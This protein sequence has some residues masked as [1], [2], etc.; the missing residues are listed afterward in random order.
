M[1]QFLE[2][3]SQTLSVCSR[4]SESVWRVLTLRGIHA[5]AGVGM[6]SHRV[7]SMVD[8]VLEILK[9][10]TTPPQSAELKNALVDLGKKSVTLWTAAQKDAAKVVV[11]ARPDPSDINKWYAEDVQSVGK[12][13]IQPDG[14]IDLTRIEPFCTFPA[15]IQMTAPNETILLHRGSALFPTSQV[16]IR[17]L[18]DQKD[19]ERELEEELLAARSKV[20]ARR[21]SYPTGPNSPTSGKYSATQH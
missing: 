3:V 12:A 13:P 10:M 18:L 15:V 2:N 8:R 6:A 16:W 19:H 1:G 20:N 9:P 7:D 21:T 5:P 17:G 11:E 4:R 14:K